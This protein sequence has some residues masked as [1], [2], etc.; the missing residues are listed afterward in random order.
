MLTYG[1]HIFMDQFR[2]NNKFFRA[3][4]ED[5]INIETIYW[6]EYHGWYFA[7]GIINTNFAE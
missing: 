1:N 3:S 5:P 6:L 7:N 2:I 4:S